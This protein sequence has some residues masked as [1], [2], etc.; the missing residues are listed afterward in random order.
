MKTARAATPK[1]LPHKKISLEQVKD[2]Y[3]AV[4]KHTEQV[5]MLGDLQLQLVCSPC[6]WHEAAECHALPVR[7]RPSACGENAPEDRPSTLGSRRRCT[8]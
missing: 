5:I 1:R 3:D 2:D 4:R 6:V 8:R 7:P